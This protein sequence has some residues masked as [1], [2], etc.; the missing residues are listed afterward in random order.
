MAIDDQG[1]LHSF[2]IFTDTCSVVTVAQE[3]LEASTSTPLFDREERLQTKQATAHPPVSITSTLYSLLATS[4]PTAERLDL[5]ERLASA[6]IL[7]QYD[8]T[9]YVDQI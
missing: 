1:S 9:E 6:R 2:A 8:L 7:L 3:S 5:V 4:H